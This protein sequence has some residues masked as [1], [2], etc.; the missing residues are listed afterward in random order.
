MTTVKTMIKQ[1]N[2]LF[3][4]RSYL[5]LVILLFV[6]I[7]LWFTPELYTWENVLFDICCFV[8]AIGGECIRIMA[9]GYAADKT[10]GRNTQQQVADEINQTGIYSMVRHPLY[11]GN[12]F[13]WLGIA[14]FTRNWWLVLVFILIYYIYYERIIMAEENFLE[15]KFGEAY[16]QFAEKV[17]CIIPRFKR[18]IP[19]KN[20][21]RLGKVLRQENSSLY[22]MMVVFIFLEIYQDFISQHQIKMERHWLYIGIIGTLVYLL[23]RV[24]KKRS[25]ILHFD[26]ER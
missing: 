15:G 17:P 24:I 3:K 25:R 23:L 26:D 6:L 7:C 5:P 19:N 12:F 16:S 2:W 10:S 9:V 21:F 14:L 8:V 18:Y 22:G 1:G 11:I 13:M 20:H 4:Y